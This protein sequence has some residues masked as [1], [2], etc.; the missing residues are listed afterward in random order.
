MIDA[1]PDGGSYY[2]LAGNCT[3]SVT[4]VTK[5]GFTVKGTLNKSGYIAKID[6]EWSGYCE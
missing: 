6:F 1:Y 4:D 3:I 2:K 5:N